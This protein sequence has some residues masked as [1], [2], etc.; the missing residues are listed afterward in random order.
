M[1][2]ASATTSSETR[3]AIARRFATLRADRRRALVPYV[4][5]GDPNSPILY[6]LEGRERDR[7]PPDVP[8][9]PPDI[10]LIQ[11]WIEEGAN[12]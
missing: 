12:P 9:P 7:M 1:A 8:L 10:A 5:P 2:S 3:D 11:R 4:T 6:L